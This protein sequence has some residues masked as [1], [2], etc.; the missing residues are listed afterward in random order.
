MRTIDNVVKSYEAMGLKAEAVHGFN[1]DSSRGWIIEFEETGVDNGRGFFKQA[2]IPGDG[3]AP[4]RN[5]SG[6]Y[7]V[8]ETGT[9]SG[10]RSDEYKELRKPAIQDDK[11]DD[12]A[13]Q[14]WFNRRAD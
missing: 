10:G 6:L 13:L 2:A 12:F 4:S 11:E 14:D 3:I 9:Y 7:Q 1:S 8:L 5:E